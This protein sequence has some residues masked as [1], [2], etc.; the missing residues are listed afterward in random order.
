VRASLDEVRSIARRL[1]PDALE[2]LGLYSALNALC[3]EFA[4]ASGVAVVPT[5]TRWSAAA[6]G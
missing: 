6:C 5:T 1:R 4:Q 3:S 2:D